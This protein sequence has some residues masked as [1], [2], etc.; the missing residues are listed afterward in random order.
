M[1]LGSGI[2]NKILQA[3]S[4]GRPVVAAPESLGG[5]NAKD[6]FNILVRADSAAFAD[7]V[8]ELILD[9]RRS[10]RLGAQGRITAEREYSWQVRAR[11]FDTYLQERSL[12]VAGDSPQFDASR[13]KDHVQNVRATGGT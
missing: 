3:W 7:A 11:Q 9:P 4:M 5:L 8:V 2:K 10:M 12:I 13:E 1:R 6:E